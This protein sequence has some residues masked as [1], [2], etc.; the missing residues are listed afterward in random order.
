MTQAYRLADEL[1]ELLNG[2]L[3]LTATPM[4]LHPFELYSLIELVE[5]G[6]FPTFDA[7]NFRRGFLPRLNALMKALRGWN[8]L[9]R[10]SSIRC[11][12]VWRRLVLTGQPPRP[13]PV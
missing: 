1:M 3:L 4:Q 13:L 12:S 2:L 8:V 9:G 6:L 5:P 10:R 7:Y 11:W